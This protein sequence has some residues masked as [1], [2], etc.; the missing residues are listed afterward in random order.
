MYLFCVPMAE[1]VNILLLLPEVA[2]IGRQRL[3]IYCSEWLQRSIAREFA[4]THLI[5]GDDLALT[6]NIDDSRA[7]FA[8]EQA[9]IPIDEL[10]GYIVDQH[11]DDADTRRRLHDQLRDIRKSWADQGYRYSVMAGRVGR[12]WIKCKNPNCDASLES[13]QEAIEGQTIHCPASLV[14]CPVCGETHS[15]DGS[16]LHLVFKD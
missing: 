16:D 8:G 15:Y 3:Q 2:A 13:A 6:V 1:S 14:T 5:V 11:F 12:L 4:V 7:R 9:F 10:V